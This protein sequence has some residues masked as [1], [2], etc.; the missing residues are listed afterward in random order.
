L[1]RFFR[2][3]HMDQI[4]SSRKELVFGDVLVEDSS[5][6]GERWLER[7]PQGRLILVNRYKVPRFKR[8]I[9]GN[10]RVT[11]VEDL[12]QLPEILHEESHRDV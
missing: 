1:E 2:I 5:E 10:P 8:P 3:D 4:H 7:H 6:H 12:S 11:V 9:D